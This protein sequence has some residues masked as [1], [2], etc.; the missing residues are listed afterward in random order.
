MNKTEKNIEQAFAKLNYCA[1]II[2]LHRECGASPQEIQ[3]YLYRLMEAGEV[4][5]YLHI[6]GAKFVKKYAK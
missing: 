5:S 4:R 2:E 3:D 6:D 1:S